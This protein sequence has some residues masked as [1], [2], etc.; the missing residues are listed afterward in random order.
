MAA[1]IFSFCCPTTSLPRSTHWLT[2]SFAS[3]PRVFR[4]SPPSCAVFLMASR[5]S[6][7]ERGAYSTPISAPKPRPARNHRKLLLLSLSDIRQPPQVSDVLT[8]PLCNTSSRKA[9]AKIGPHGLGHEIYN[10]LTQQCQ[11]FYPA[12]SGIVVI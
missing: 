2:V 1:L 8:R 3:R 5:V 9:L 4:Y 7:P 6:R 10:I 11:V 12:T